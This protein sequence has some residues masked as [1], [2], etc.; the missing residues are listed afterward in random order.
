MSAA[1]PDSDPLVGVVGA[2]GAVGRG[3]IEALG[4]LG[5]NRLRLGARSGDA[6]AALADGRSGRTE[7]RRVDVTDPESMRSFAPGCE[8]VST[9][10]G[11]SYALREAV[12]RETVAAGSACVEVTGDAPVKAALEPHSVPR[13]VLLSAGVLPGLSALLPRLLADAGT[14]DGDDPPVGLT[15]WAGGLEPCTSTV[16]TD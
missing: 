15:G 6:V 1:G 14:S 4:R 3:A 2:T 11:P 8:V 7:G 10:A 13:P 16:A 5:V 12:A 9:C